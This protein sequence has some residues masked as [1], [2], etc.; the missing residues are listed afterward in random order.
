MSNSQLFIPEG[1]VK[2]KYFDNKL[3]SSPNAHRFI[4]QNDL[5]KL[6]EDFH[7]K[8]MLRNQYHDHS[9]SLQYLFGLN[10]LILVLLL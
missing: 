7:A 8:M 6:S 3:F 10:H 9:K 4:M 5:N 2:L 1:K